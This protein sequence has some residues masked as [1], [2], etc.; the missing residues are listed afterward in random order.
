MLLFAVCVSGG[1]GGGGGGPKWR[2]PGAKEGVPQPHAPPSPDAN[3]ALWRSEG[4]VHVELYEFTR[5][6]AAT[7]PYAVDTRIAFS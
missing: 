7:A 1:V 2:L 3:G 6:A 5:Q 4:R